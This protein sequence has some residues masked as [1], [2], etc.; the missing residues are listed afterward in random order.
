MQISDR[1][2]VSGLE[3][4][5][6]LRRGN[7]TQHTAR[8]QCSDLFHAELGESAAGSDV[9]DLDTVVELPVDAL[10]R[11]HVELRPDLAELGGHQFL[12]GVALV[13]AHRSGGALGMQIESASAD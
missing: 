8:K 1:N 6:T 2:L 7:I 12:V 10:M 3:H 13:A 9:I 5:D 4:L 11:E